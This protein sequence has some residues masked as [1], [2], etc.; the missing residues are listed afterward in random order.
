MLLIWTTAAF[1]FLF[2]VHGVV[3]ENKEYVH[4]YALESPQKKQPHQSGLSSTT[5]SYRNLQ[6]SNILVGNVTSFVMINTNT[7]LPI[8]VLLNNT[9]INLSAI[10]TTKL[11]IQALISPSSPT[12]KI[13]EIQFG[14]DDDFDAGTERTAP[15]SLCGN[16][17]SQL[18]PCDDL[19]VGSHTVWATPYYNG[20]AGTSKRVTFRIVNT[21]LTT[22]SCKIPRVRLATTFSIDFNLIQLKPLFIVF[23]NQKLFQNK[24]DPRHLER[25]LT[26]LSNEDQR[27]TGS[28][29]WLRYCGNVGIY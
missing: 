2:P 12:S 13:D 14:F 6:E 29:D 18:L 24:A 23:L 16:I 15:Y 17:N 21:T 3:V 28:H 27:N 7:N 1:F 4:L 10:Q 22:K 9:V 19:T 5:T 11:T 25:F 8:R 20:K 26:T